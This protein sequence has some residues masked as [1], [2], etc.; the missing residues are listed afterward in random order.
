[1]SEDIRQVTQTS[2]SLWSNPYE[3][4]SLET[5][6]LYGERFRVE[7]KK[8]LP[9]GSTMCFGTSLVDGYQGWIDPDV[10]HKTLYNPTHRVS[11][12]RVV[13]FAKPDFKSMHVGALSMNSLVRVVKTED[14]SVGEYAQLNN[15]HWVFAD[16]LRKEGEYSKDFVAEAAK[17]E[18]FEYLWG[19]RNTGNGVDCSSLLQHAGHACGMAFPRNSSDQWKQVGVP[20]DG[21]EMG[22]GQLVFWPGHCGVMVNQLHILHA[23]VYSRRVVREPL[24]KAI[25]ERGPILGRKRIV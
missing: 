9:D 24:E 1:M 14:S 25:A 7:S 12:A 10:L 2:V 19:G 11:A 17:L 18:G 23:S 16:Q 13:L 22:R 3:E 15:G 4:G 8:R 21:E 20:Y 6:L 5:E